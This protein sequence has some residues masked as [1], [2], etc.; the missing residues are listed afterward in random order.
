MIL[1]CSNTQVERDE[2]L[3]RIY[4]A[5]GADVA[6]LENRGDLFAALMGRT[7]IGMSEDNMFRLYGSLLDNLFTECINVE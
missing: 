3:R 1:Q 4:A 2:M 6:L 5:I 7:I